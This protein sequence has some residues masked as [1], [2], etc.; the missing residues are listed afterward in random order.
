MRFH[1]VVR[2]VGE[3]REAIDGV[4]PNALIVWE[5][6]ADAT[7]DQREG[8]VE[9]RPSVVYIRVHAPTTGMWQEW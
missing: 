7:L 4:D 2:T 5:H 6:V 3:L 1:T 8:V 9:A